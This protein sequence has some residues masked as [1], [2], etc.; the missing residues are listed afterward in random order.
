M[1]VG[2]RSAKTGNTK[3]TQVQADPWKSSETDSSFMAICY[4]SYTAACEKDWKL[5]EG[6]FCCCSQRSQSLWCQWSASLPRVLDILTLMVP[7]NVKFTPT[8]NVTQSIYLY[9][10][11]SISLV[12]MYWEAPLIVLISYFLQ[13]TILW[14]YIFPIQYKIYHDIHTLWIHQNFC[15]FQ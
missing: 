11:F 3:H 2:W 15:H 6:V 5:L 1:Q 12:L 13:S 9:Q 8:L 4:N 10:L 14:L 7:I